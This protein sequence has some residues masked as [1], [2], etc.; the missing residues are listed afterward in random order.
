MK[1]K[2]TIDKKIE[3]PS[4]I[5]EISA[6]SLEHKLDFIDEKNIEGY[7]LLTG[8]YKLTEASRLEDDFEYKIPAEIILSESVDLSDT[9]IEITDFSYEIE[10]DIVMNCHI[11]LLIEGLELINMEEDSEERECDGD[12]PEEKEIEIP[13]KEEIIEL[14]VD[15]EEKSDDISVQGS[16]FTNLSDEQDSFGTFIVY[17][18]RQNE[19]VNTII[20]KYATSLEELEKYN[21]LSDLKDGT[22]LIVPVKNE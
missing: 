4:M 13:K 2:V 9:K 21:D 16:L 17:I 20:E 6:I 12:L 14:R 7:F 1:K 8:K 22:K 10:D 15:E 3:F 19:T 18:V 5:G 11:E